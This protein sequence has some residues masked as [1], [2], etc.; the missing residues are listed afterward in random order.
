MGEERDANPVPTQFTG[1]IEL[2][3]KKRHQPLISIAT[4]AMASINISS[5]V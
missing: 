4:K 3:N 5:W 2:K 1:M